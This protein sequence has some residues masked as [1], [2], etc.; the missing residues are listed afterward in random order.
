M[1]LLSAALVIG[2]NRIAIASHCNGVVYNGINPQHVP[3]I[4]QAL[5]SLA[6][7]VTRECYVSAAEL[8]RWSLAMNGT[9][10]LSFLSLSSSTGL[11]GL[12]WLIAKGRTVFDSWRLLAMYRFFVL[13]IVLF[14][15]HFIWLLH[16]DSQTAY[17]PT[18][19]QFGQTHHLGV[20]KFAFPLGQP[21]P[22]SQ[23][24]SW[25]YLTDQTR[26]HSTIPTTCVPNINGT[27]QAY[28]IFAPVPIN[29]T[30]ACLSPDYEGCQNQP[31]LWFNFTCPDNVCDTIGIFSNVPSYL[32]EFEEQQEE[33]S[34]EY[35]LNHTSSLGV[36]VLMCMGN[37]TPES[38]SIDFFWDICSDNWPSRPCPLGTNS[39]SATRAT[40]HISSANVTFVFNLS[41]QTILDVASVS[42]TPYPLNVSAF[43]QAYTAPLAYSPINF[44][45]LYD[46]DISHIRPSPQPIILGENTTMVADIWVDSVFYDLV[47][48]VR[49]EAYNEL[50]YGFVAQGLAANSRKFVDDGMQRNWTLANEVQVLCTPPIT[51]WVF[52]ALMLGVISMAAGMCI[53]A[54]V[55]NEYALELT[56]FPEVV[57]GSKIGVQMGLI[58]R[59]LC[60]ANVN[61]VLDTLKSKKLKVSMDVNRGVTLLS[62][63]LADGR[64]I[65]KQG[66]VDAAWRWKIPSENQNRLEK[67]CRLEDIE[68]N[69]KGLSTFRVSTFVAP[70][71]FS[72]F[73]VSPFGVH[74]GVICDFDREV[75]YLFHLLF[76]PISREF[77][78]EPS[79]WQPQWEH[80]QVTEV[81]T[82]CYGPVDVTAT[83]TM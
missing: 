8:L 41:N 54:Y 12:A 34:W 7:L 2:T 5:T 45:V 11:V 65:S 1:I 27:C 32:V 69:P 38:S 6:I 35:C 31:S 39:E 50:V 51:I 80:N 66:I 4:I 43:F 3:S 18:G 74:W 17:K 71:N 15:S 28:V 73:A 81:G 57:F 67:S 30:Y 63:D 9:P 78:F 40:I 44:S 77:R 25:R 23:S 46:A 83:G 61:N 21:W 16:T 14:V 79:L 29:Y 56:A 55:V 72:N 20:D 60:N 49:A 24:D 42:A 52:T 64:E 33:I 10:A 13:Y 36:Q 37:G 59:P 76:D 82:T 22:Y 75:R 53:Y 48:F 68:V 26:V 58:L 70:K 62:E 47:N 19:P